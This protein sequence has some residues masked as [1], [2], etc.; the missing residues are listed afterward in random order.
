MSGSG[1]GN[2]TRLMKV[3]GLPCSHCIHPASSI[4]ISSIVI[5]Q[6]IR[7]SAIRHILADA[8]SR[9]LIDNKRRELPPRVK[10]LTNSEPPAIEA[11]TRI[12]LFHFFHPFSSNQTMI[13]T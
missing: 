5:L 10:I 7:M 2:R 4:L 6:K 13:P 11:F 1:G 3:M 8:L 12:N 9:L